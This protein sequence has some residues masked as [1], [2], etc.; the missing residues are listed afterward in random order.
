MGEKALLLAQNAYNNKKKVAD[1]IDY[2]KDLCS[3]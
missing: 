1:L 2:Y 3:R